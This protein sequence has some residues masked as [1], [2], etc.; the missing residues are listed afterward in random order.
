MRK[1]VAVAEADDTFRDVQPVNGIP[2]ECPDR[3]AER[4]HVIYLR[5]YTSRSASAATE[6]RERRREE[7]HEGERENAPGVCAC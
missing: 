1:A 4:Q 3:R 7:E 5:L 6:A 2:F